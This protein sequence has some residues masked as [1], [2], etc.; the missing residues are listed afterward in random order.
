MYIT[1]IRKEGDGFRRLG[2]GQGQSQHRQRA[3]ERKL[4]LKK[5]RRSTH[6]LSPK[7]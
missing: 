1:G 6:I 4:E 2:T 7:I 5:E 3:N